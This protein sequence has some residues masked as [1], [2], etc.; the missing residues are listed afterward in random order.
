MCTLHRNMLSHIQAKT[1][2]I[3]Q[4]EEEQRGSLDR[5]SSPSTSHSAPLAIP[6]VG[7]SVLPQS[8]R[9]VKQG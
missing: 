2:M 1:L 8:I 9:C 3:D 7:H 6:L 4:S 5:S